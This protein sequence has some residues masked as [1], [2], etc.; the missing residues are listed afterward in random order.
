MFLRAE[1][2]RRVWREAGWPEAGMSARRWR[3]LAILARNQRISRLAIGAGVE[4]TTTG[5]TGKPT[6]PVRVATHR[7]RPRSPEHGPALSRVLAL[8]VPG[9]AAWGDGL[10]RTVLEPESPRDETIDLDRIVLPLW[11][12]VRGARRPIP[13]AGHG[14]QE[15]STE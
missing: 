9:A 11:V 4:L 5:G 3:R 15:H 7:H 1:V 6:Q 13:A 8:D 10:I 14:G 12:R 2:L